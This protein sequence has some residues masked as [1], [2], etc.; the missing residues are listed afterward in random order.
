MHADPLAVAARTEAGM[1]VDETDPPCVTQVIAKNL[2]ERAVRPGRLPAAVEDA[3]IVA[4]LPA[5]HG[6]LQSLDPVLL[7]V[8]LKHP[9]GLGHGGVGPLRRA[10]RLAQFLVALVDR[11]VR[12]VV[13]H[14]VAV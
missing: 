4:V 5:R 10:N 8:V 9:V 11:I 1:I 3:L 12:L 13:V 6:G 2:H 14:E 7:G